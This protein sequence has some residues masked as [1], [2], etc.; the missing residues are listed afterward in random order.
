MNSPS[1][2]NTHPSDLQDKTALVTGATLGI[3]RATA[4]GLARQGM[5]VVIAGR[6]ATKA[7]ETVRAIQSQTG[8]PRV[9]ALIADLFVPAQ[10]RA[11]A[12]EFQR[13][14]SRLDVLVNNA[15]GNFTEH[16][17]IGGLERTWAL[18]HLAYVQ[19]SLALLPRLKASAPSRIV[20]VASGW[21]A[22]RLNFDD[23]Q[24]ERHFS[25]PGAYFQSKL[26][27][28]LFTNAL[29]R[30]LQGTGVTANAVNPGIVDTGIAREVTGVGKFLSGLM[31]PLKKPV[32]QGAFPSLYMAL[33]PDVEGLT[34]KFFDKTKF[35]ETSTVTH[36]VA[37]QERLWQ[38][39][40]EQL[41][42][43]I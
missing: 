37:V 25:G 35:V 38:V 18:N 24:G 26:A 40:L 9:S 1:V 32:E 36:D 7:Q 14:H 28:L 12:E 29:A 4:L 22:K 17:L 11:L 42:L 13:Q 34:G 21:Y 2:S 19:L 8:N 33:S 3:G 23:L 20:N 15:G 6:D 39:S 43:A 5:T 30:R 10:V 41:G 16:K 31:K 27:N